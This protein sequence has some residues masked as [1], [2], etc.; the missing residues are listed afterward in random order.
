MNVWKGSVGVIQPFMKKCFGGLNKESVE[1]FEEDGSDWDDPAGSDPD[2]TWRQKNF[3]K[4]YEAKY[5]KLWNYQNLK[6]RQGKK[7]WIAE[8]WSV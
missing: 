4:K 6:I 3:A 7:E 5:A 1:L 8:F 2:N